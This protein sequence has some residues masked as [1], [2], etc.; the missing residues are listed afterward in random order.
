MAKTKNKPTVMAIPPS[1][2]TDMAGRHLETGDPFVM[3]AIVEIEVEGKFVPSIEL[4]SD[5]GVKNLSTLL[6]KALDSVQS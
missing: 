6:Q 1:M 3:V 5:L 2:A 4:Y